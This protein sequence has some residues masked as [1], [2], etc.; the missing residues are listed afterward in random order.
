MKY[1]GNPRLRNVQVVV[2]CMHIVQCILLQDRWTFKI[3]ELIDHFTKNSWFC[4]YIN[5]TKFETNTTSKS[6][7]YKSK[8]IGK[9]NH[10]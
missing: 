1:A 9:N 7:R 4:I 6:G 3:L 2:V 8:T 10:V 5:P